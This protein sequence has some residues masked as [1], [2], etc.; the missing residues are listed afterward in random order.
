MPALRAH[1]HT[2]THLT[3]IHKL[4]F[5]SARSQPPTM[6]QDKWANHWERALPR[7]QRNQDYY[8]AL[9]LRSRVHLCVCVYVCVHMCPFMHGWDQWEYMSQSVLCSAY[10]HR[11]WGPVAL[12]TLLS[13]HPVKQGNMRERRV[14]CITVECESELQRCTLWPLLTFT[15]YL[16]FHCFIKPPVVVYFLS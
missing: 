3:Y 15:V 16:M 1:T 10:L 8:P 14:R 5:I 6:Q 12:S 13:S 7:V 11:S 2:H 9:V 4:K